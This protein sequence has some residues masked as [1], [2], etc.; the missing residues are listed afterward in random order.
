MSTCTQGG[1]GFDTDLSVFELLQ[2]GVGGG[3]ELVQRACNG[4]SYGE[5]GCQPL[6]SRLSFAA[7][8]ATYFVAVARRSGVLGGNVTLTTTLALPP[9]PPGVPPPAPP[10][11]PPLDASTDLQILIDRAPSGPPYLVLLEPTVRLWSTLVIPAGKQILLRGQSTRNRTRLQMV[12]QSMAGADTRVRH[13]DVQHGAALYLSNLHVEGG[14]ATDVSGSALGACGG[15]VLIRGG[16]R[17]VAQY[18]RFERNVAELG[19]AICAVGDGEIELLAVEMDDNFANLGGYDMYLGRP[20]GT[21]PPRVDLLGLTL[22]SPLEGLPAVAALVHVG[23]WV[24]SSCV[25]D[26]QASCAFYAPQPYTTHAHA[27][28]C[29]AFRGGGTG[30]V[31]GATCRCTGGLASA[32]SAEAASLAPYGISP[33]DGLIIDHRSR[34]AVGQCT[35]TFI[36]EV[37]H[38]PRRSIVVQLI[39]GSGQAEHKFSNITVCPL[40]RTARAVHQSRTPCCAAHPQTC[41]MPCR[42]GRASVPTPSCSSPR[43][44]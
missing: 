23:A 3:C 6:Y 5:V 4:D 31:F 29:S 18:C 21:A 37:A 20:V 11:P 19:G 14:V 7:S 40:A 13:F 42:I 9:E 35:P 28:T 36:A 33:V 8:G 30:H 12:P 27:A 22:G 44:A 41:G 10:P 34:R 38:F 32:E 26:R 2:D 16:G 1:G 25:H 43:G 17:L 15:A 24:T 39:K